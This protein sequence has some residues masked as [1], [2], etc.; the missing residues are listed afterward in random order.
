MAVILL[1]LRP[2]LGWRPLLV[3]L[4]PWGVRLLAGRFPF[5]RTTIDVP[6]A[7]FLATAGVG[8]W[9]AYD[10]ET[11]WAKFWL[12]VASVL[13]FYAL[14]GQPQKN[15]WLIA[16]FLS[17]VG[18]GT[19]LFFLFT[20][21]WQDQPAKIG[22]LQQI[23]LRWMDVR[24]SVPLGSIHPNDSASVM[25]MMTPFLIAIGDRAR[26]EK[27]RTLVLVVLSIGMVV[28]VSFLL[29]T[30]RGAWVASGVALAAWFLW[31]LSGWLFRHNPIQRRSAFGLTVFLFAA[32]GIGLVLM[33]P[34]S[35]VR[36]AGTLPGPNHSI[37]R[38]E[39]ANSALNLVEDYPFTGG[40]LRTFSGLYSHYILDIPFFITN[41]SHDLYLDVTLE[42]G[43]LGLLAYSFVLVGSF[44]YLASGSLSPS[45]APLRWAILAGMI[46][47]SV[48]GLVDDI[49]YNIEG[50]PLL[51]L[52]PGLALAIPK[53][54]H[55]QTKVVMLDR[56][57]N[58]ILRPIAVMVVLVA[59]ILAYNFRQS[60]EASW[61]ADLGAVQMA[62]IELA[63]FPSGKWTDGSESDALKP[64]EG[65]FHHA[66]Q[67][68][69]NN[70]TAHHRL[71]LIAM[72]RRDY[73]TAIAHLEKAHALD[74]NHRGI[75]KL[76]GYSY[77]WAGQLDQAADMLAGISEAK[78]EMRVYIW[79]WGTQG[80]QDLANQAEKI[81]QLL[82]DPQG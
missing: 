33:F 43:I 18:L 76:L 35:I 82:R 36:L 45:I 3:A 44:W 10:R 25:A 28:L 57:R 65:W 27:R 22:F 29:T 47:M 59:L 58:S 12:L 55:Q 81:A 26:R 38:L 48:H 54:R 68:N 66:L 70:R 13:L 80:R 34:G 15:L 24:F 61:Y 41:I 52:L 53:S 23:G 9:A 31:I 72:L 73:P 64:A 19:A 20:H 21:N 71:G 51:F 14:A 77:V 17:L 6:L 62:R 2:Q 74:G 56:Q 37:S 40:G 75:R 7:L 30:S 39:L 32:L 63:D 11:A 46:V 60:L 1:E 69:P 4:I 42:Q 5:K 8:V 16:A 50:C 78:S 67:L 79:W 49:V